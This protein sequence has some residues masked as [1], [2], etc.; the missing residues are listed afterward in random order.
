MTLALFA[1][2]TLA[3]GQDQAAPAPATPAAQAAPREAAPADPAAVPPPAVAP[4]AP[5]L[6]A[7][8]PASIPSGANVAVI[9]IEGMIYDF[10][11][12]NLR[13]RVDRA[14]ADG[15]TL[16]VL[17][18][19]TPGGVA[20][21][22]LEIAKYIKGD[23]NVPTV[24]WINNHAY[25]AG[26]LIASACDVIVMSPASATGDCAPIVP[27]QELSPTERAKALSP[28]LEEFRDNAD[29]NGYPY[30]L[31]H[32]MCVLGVEVYQIRHK[33]TG[34]IQLVN[35]IDYQIMVEG[36][37]PDGNWLTQMIGGS[38]AAA[39]PDPNSVE[40]GAVSRQLARDEDRGQWELVK[41]IHDGKTLLTLNQTRAVECGLALSDQVRNRNQLGQYLGAATTTDIDNTWSENLAGWLTSLP[42]RSVLVIALLLGA[43]VEFQTPGVGL[44]GAVALAALVLLIGAPFLVGLSEVWH[45]LLFFLGLA[46]LIVELTVLPGFGV[47]GVSGLVCMFV[48]L[49]LAVVPT[50]TAG[51]LSLP[52]PEM[53]GRLQMS[54]LWML[55]G[56]IG[57]L[58]GFYFLARYY[59][60]IPVLNRLV[61]ANP[62]PATGLAQH[63]SGDEAL[64]AR[65]MTVGQ[66]GK[67]ISLLRPIGQGEF[68]GHVIDVQSQGEWLEPGT[69]VKIIEISGNRI[70]VAAV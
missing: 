21:S 43:Y 50:A 18:L 61:L 57:A 4:R 20:T 27:G 47:C 13:R 36:K 35:Q 10:T 5:A 62:Q 51:P 48:G 31:F 25:S 37:N 53:W 26:I 1:P 67:V 40:P 34:E 9:R 32:A 23:I 8:L 28:L 19:D 2:R 45:V 52:A 11:L 14:L 6:T 30:V 65:Q 64:G 56:L 69:P 24:A 68:A 58:V 15:A 55:L 39:N 49:V 44:P 60:E 70:V 33:Q 3:P 46:L 54:T 17:E 22:A 7:P 41:Q 29:S 12:E 66:T 38:N 42:V 59:T 16:I 63:V